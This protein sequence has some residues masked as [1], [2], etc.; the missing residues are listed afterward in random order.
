MYPQL[1]W[2]RRQL[3]RYRNTTQAVAKSSRRMLDI[4]CGDGEK[5]LRFAA[6]PIAKHGVEV[7]FERLQ[8]A[9]RHGLT[10]E[11]ATATHLPFA[12]N[13]FDFVYVAHV[14]HH[15]ADYPTVL[16]EIQRVLSA[17]GRVFINESVSDSPLLRLGRAIHPVWQGDE[18]ENAWSYADLQQIFH[19]A[20]YTVVESRQYNVF[21]FLWEMLPIAFW[22]LELFTPLFVYLDLLL[23]R[24]FNR[25][26]AHCYFILRPNEPS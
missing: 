6:L 22:P 17:D 24:F 10:V 12:D 11:Q 21:F 1:T 9:R 14:L 7:S 23:E 4:G 25:W 15:I 16:A 26:S 19:D 5:L 18:L 3:F 2:F 8:T 13:A 20:G